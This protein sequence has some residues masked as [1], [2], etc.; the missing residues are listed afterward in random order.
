MTEPK[1]MTCVLIYGGWTGW[2]GAQM[3]ELCKAE[4]IEVHNASARIENRTDL[5][6]ELDEIKPSHV[7]MAAG[8]TGRPNIDWCEGRNHSCQCDWNAHRG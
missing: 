6:A 8:I 7:F 5:A 2:I 1:P 3:N 4:G